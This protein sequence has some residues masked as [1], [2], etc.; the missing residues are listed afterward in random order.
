[1]EI[2]PRK[3]QANVHSGCVCASVES[4]CVQR[5][6]NPSALFRNQNSFQLLS[7]SG[8]DQRVRGRLPG[9][10]L[11]P[12]EYKRIRAIYLDLDPLAPRLRVAR[13]IR[14]DIEITVVAR[15]H[16]SLTAQVAGPSYPARRVRRLHVP[17]PNYPGPRSTMQR[18]LRLQSSAQHRPEITASPC[19]S[20]HEFA[21]RRNSPASRVLWEAACKKPPPWNEHTVAPLWELEPSAL[22]HKRIQGPERGWIG[23]QVEPAAQKPHEEPQA[24]AS[25]ARRQQGKP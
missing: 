25:F 1:M 14:Q 6:R 17:P 20:G 16:Q 7:A 24:S 21:P 23:R 2:V 10:V 11:V 19:P 4:G 5:H 8:T 15:G 3:L 18:A 22:G 9:A 13:D 12:R